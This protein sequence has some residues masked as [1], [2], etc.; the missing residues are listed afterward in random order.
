MTADVVHGVMLAGVGVNTCCVFG[1]R[2]LRTRITVV[3]T[4]LMAVAMLDVTLGLGGLPPLVWTAILIGWGIASAAA[5]RHRAAA[6]ALSPP[7]TDAA[8]PSLPLPSL[9]LPSLGL[10]SLP[11]RS[12]P[13]RHASS[14]LHLHHS[15]G[16]IVLAAQLAA[17]GIVGAT[18][19]AG[20]SGS[21][22]HSL[23]ALPLLGAVGGL[24]FVAYSVLLLLST[25][26]SRLERGTLASMAVMTLAMGLMP[27]V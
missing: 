4:L 3:S 12:L 20:E 23:T 26:R 13:L 2:R 11:L 9:P 19:S 22:V 15:I 24:L 25:G 14:T 18:A 5:T 8:R 16:L 21:H 1:S 27:V 6:T 17:H 10:C 7:P